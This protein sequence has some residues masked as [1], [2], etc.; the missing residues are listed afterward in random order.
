[1]KNAMKHAI[2]GLLLLA[3]S[4]NSFG[5]DKEKTSYVSSPMPQ[6]LMVLTRN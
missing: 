3:V 1:M 4:F 6:F 5:Q 2:L